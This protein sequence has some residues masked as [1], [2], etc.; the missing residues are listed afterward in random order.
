G[1]IAGL[2]RFEPSVDRFFAAA[3]AADRWNGSLYALPWFVDVG[4]LYWRKDLA[5]RAPRDLN[6]LMQLARRAQKE[7][8]VPFGFVWQGARYEGLV[9]VFLEHLG[10]FGVAIL[11]DRG[12]VVVDSAAAVQALTYMRDAIYV[13]GIVPSAVLTWQE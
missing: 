5:S 13:E 10:A 12:A 3:V 6:E 7:A 8:R 1:W 9:T 2:D 11:D 4:M